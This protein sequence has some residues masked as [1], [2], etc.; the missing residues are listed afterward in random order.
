M[1]FAAHGDLNGRIKRH[2]SFQTHFS[3]KRILTWFAQLASA[4]RE[5]HERGLI[6]R[7]IKPANVFLTA[8]DRV[9][10]GDFGIAC[11]VNRSEEQLGRSTPVGTPMYMAPEIITEDGYDQK[12]DIW[13][14]GCVLY[15][16]IQLFPAFYGKN[17]HSL[18]RNIKKGRFIEDFPKGYSEELLGLLFP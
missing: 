14:L 4:V 16:M 7:D 12:T 1:E 10:L 18:L 11:P 13:A 6:H 2:D 17:V 5:I 8:D 3:E 9:K 15:E